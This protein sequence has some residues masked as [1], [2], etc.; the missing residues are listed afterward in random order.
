V[1]QRRMAPASVHIFPGETYDFE[2]ESS[3]PVLRLRMRNPNLTEGDE[4]TLE[5][6]TR[7]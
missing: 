7:P 5:L 4:A 1:G 3:A 6:R 2:F